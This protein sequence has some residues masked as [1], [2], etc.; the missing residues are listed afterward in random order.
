MM[1]RTVRWACVVAAEE[2]LSAFCP[3]LRAPTARNGVVIAS[4]SWKSP[5]FK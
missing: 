2:P 5:V 3:F 1:G 4:I